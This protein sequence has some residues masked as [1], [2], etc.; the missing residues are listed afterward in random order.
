MNVRYSLHKI[1]NAHSCPFSALEYSRFKFGDIAYAEKFAKQLFNGFIAQHE[2]LILSQQ[3]IILLPSPFHSIPTASNFL[4]FFFKKYLN[5]FLFKYGKAAC[6]ESKIHRRQTYVEDYG[7][8]DY[9]QRINLISN[10]TY[11]LD[12]AFIAGKCCIFLDDIKITGGH[13]Q[14]VNN[15]LEQYAVNGEFIFLYFAELVDTSIHP[16]IENYYNYFDIK[17]VHDIIRIMNSARFRFNTRVI[18]YILLMKK[19]EF[20]QVI[21]HITQSKRNELLDL[22]ISNNYHQI[23]EYRKNILLLKTEKSCQLT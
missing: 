3:E 14:T 4:C 15:I 1:D 11:Y 12:R 22:A 8:M 7:N 23:K 21:Q 16:R 18:K 6:K 19:H 20:E 9:Q 2:E 5:R 13:E 10:D 17:S